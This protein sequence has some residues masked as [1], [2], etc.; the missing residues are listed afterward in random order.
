MIALAGLLAL[1]IVGWLAVELGWWNRPDRSR[2]PCFGV[3]VSHHQGDID[4]PRVRADSIVFAYVKAT[5]GADFVD[6]RFV[7]NWRGAHAAHLRVGAYHFFSFCRSPEEQAEHFLATVP[8]DRSALP[9]VLD[10]EL[11][12]SCASMPPVEEVRRALHRWLEIVARRSGRRPM[13]YVTREAYA[14][15]VREAGFGEAIWIR[16]IWRE[17]D[18]RELPFTLWQ[19]QARARVDGV[20]GPV[21]LDAFAGNGATFARW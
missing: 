13:V 21:D 14:R 6:P 7:E 10:V 20:E 5:E 1:F 18:R 8:Q 4:W 15:F 17:P 3:D 2:Y 9:A 12:G 11:G 16:D 19:F